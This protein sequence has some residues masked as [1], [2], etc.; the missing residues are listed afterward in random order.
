VLTVAWNRLTGIVDERLNAI[1]NAN[2]DHAQHQADLAA[3][4]GQVSELQTQVATL[5]QALETARTDI[6]AARRRRWRR[7]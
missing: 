7:A 3:I 5:R 2:P 1:V 6:A 4:R